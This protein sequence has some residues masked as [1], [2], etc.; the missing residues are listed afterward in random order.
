MEWQLPVLIMRA[1]QEGCSG[2]HARE[3]VQDLGAEL[4]ELSMPGS[5]PLEQSS[6]NKPVKASE[7]GSPV[8][9][10]SRCMLTGESQSDA[11]ADPLSP[12]VCSLEHCQI[13]R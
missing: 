6:V 9:R 3:A 10:C 5:A 13:R 1:K 4:T 7:H 11:L 2:E 12:H 8:D